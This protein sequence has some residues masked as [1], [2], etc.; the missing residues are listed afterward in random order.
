MVFSRNPEA[1][2]RFNGIC[3][4]LLLVAT[5]VL[6]PAYNI[7]SINY[8]RIAVYACSL[9]SSWVP[10][11]IAHSIDTVI[12]WLLMVAVVYLFWKGIPVRDQYRASKRLE[13][14][15]HLIN[16]DKLQGMPSFCRV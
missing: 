13:K 9:V 4:L 7:R 15:S 16:E 2:K 10:N 5:I 3:L 11:I 1:I 12:Y 8:T 14:Q 6:Q